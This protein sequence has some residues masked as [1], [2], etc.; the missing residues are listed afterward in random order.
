LVYEVPYNTGGA[1]FR[2]SMYPPACPLMPA[3]R[4]LAQRKTL[5]RQGSFSPSGTLTLDTNV[6]LWESGFVDGAVV[7]G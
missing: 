4:P 1:C 2:Q 6:K 7:D 5:L 3:Q